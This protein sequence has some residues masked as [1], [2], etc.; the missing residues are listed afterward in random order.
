MIIKTEKEYRAH[1]ALNFSSISN[2]DAS[3]TLYLH[4]RSQKS[5]HDGDKAYFHVGSA[6]DCMLTDGEEAFNKQF[7]VGTVD[8]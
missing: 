6:L 7:V 3:P 5:K 4:N 2:F 1:P 8:A